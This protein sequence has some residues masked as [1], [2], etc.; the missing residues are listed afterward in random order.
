LDQHGSSLPLAERMKAYEARETART[1][2]P[3]APIVAR[4]DGRAFHTF[5]RG[6][7]RPYDPDMV[8]AMVRTTKMLVA[9]THARIGYAQSDEI[10]LVWL[11]ERFD[12]SIFF[13]GRVFK[14]T[15]V[16]AGLATAAFT[17]AILDIGD[18]FATYADHMPHFDARVFQVPTREEAANVFL[19]RNL[20]ATR[21]ALNMAASCYYSE[22]ELYGKNS[23]DKHEMLHAKGVNFND[24]P[25]RF[26]RGV[27]VRRVV[28]ERP[29]TE[30][31]LARIPERHRPAPDAVV[32]RSEVR[33]FSVPPFA[34]VANRVAVVFDGA[35]PV[36]VAEGA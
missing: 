15:S 17:R 6:M 16:L 30:D 20:D 4:I 18:E 12:Q 11:A 14:M 10:N 34:R 9:M 28:V 23:G 7:R 22:R 1:F 19:W 21:N 31:E 5:T 26:K 35:D 24:C 36:P 3:M 32:A 2:L 8:E 29:F 25:E 33:E 27:W 13:D